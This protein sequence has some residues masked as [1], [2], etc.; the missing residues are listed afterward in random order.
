[1]GRP[2]PAST[3]HRRGADIRMAARGRET[4][5]N[6]PAQL[7]FRTIGG[8]ERG[9]AQCTMGGKAETVVSAAAVPDG[10]L[11]KGLRPEQGQGGGSMRKG[12]IL[13]AGTGSAGT[14]RPNPARPG[15]P[16]QNA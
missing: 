14:P 12:M 8:N 7:G 15:T 3:G 5:R 2:Y 13:C 6:A 16:Q 10:I 4:Q 1:M 9:L 11:L